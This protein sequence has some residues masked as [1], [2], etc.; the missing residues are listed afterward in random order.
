VTIP[1]GVSEETLAAIAKAQTTGITS[2]TGI[3][4][5][6]LS[7]MVSLVPVVTPMRDQT[8]RVQSTDGA[9]F[10]D[11]RAVMNATANQPDPSVAFDYAANAIVISEQDFRAVYKP[12]GY[13]VSV[14][15]D[16]YDLARGYAD[17]YA[18]A[19]FQAISQLKIG[20]DRKQIG[21]QSFALATAAA[22]ALTKATTGGSIDASGAAV[23]MYVA[24]A[25][26]TGS[27][28]YYGSGNSRAT[29]SADANF[30]TGGTATNKLTATVTALR[31]AVCYDWFQSA[32]NSTWYYYG[33][34][35]VNSIVMT[36]V[37]AADQALPSMVLMPGLSTSWKGVASTKPTV[38]VA[39]DNG[40]ANAAD[41]DGLLA[42]LSGDYSSTGQWVTPGAGTLNPSAYNSL[43]GAAMTFAGGTVAEIENYIFLQLWHQVQCSPTAIM[44]NAAQAQ[45]IA[46]LVLSS[47]ASNTFLNTDAD[48]RINITAGGRV[49][50]LVNAP[51]GGAVVPIEVHPSLPPG[52]IIG[53]TDRVPFPQAGIT[54]V[55]EYR[56]LR[57]MAQY[58]YGTSR[59]ANTAGGGPRRESEVRCIGAFIN[60][61]PVAMA[62]IS[63]VG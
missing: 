23:H 34:T 29:A 9:K 20:E 47:T 61:A 2:A 53:R 5:V 41:T 62:T 26:R 24:A 44:M 56:T 8:A 11:W 30:T 36:K 7:E 60:R 16:A 22:P 58:E 50:H 46:N 1:A 32:D 35:S 31:G 4:S 40:S 25:G 43:D 27:G 19:T 15:Q 3:T 63:N 28:Y 17:P 37:I 21:A 13:S 6:D 39:A 18:V 48:G 38:S 42:S 55:L 51:A 49:G 57:D 45:S 52:T 54:S 33:T 59:V 10:A 14:T 12:L